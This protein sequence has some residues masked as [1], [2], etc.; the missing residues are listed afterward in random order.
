MLDARPRPQREPPPGLLQ[1]PAEVGV[2]G[3]AHAL[4]EPADLFERDATHEQ[5]R[6]DR[7]RTVGVGNVGLLAE[8]APRGAV[9]CGDRAAIRRRDHLACERAEVGIGRLGEIRVEQP[10]RRVAIGIQKQNPI[11]PGSGRADVTSI[12]G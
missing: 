8:E 3:R 4:V 10:M 7:A 9:A 1:S 2:L 11:A 5:V 12:G 6:G